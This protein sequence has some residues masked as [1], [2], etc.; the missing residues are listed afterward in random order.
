M[1]LDVSYAN[2]ATQASMMKVLV[3]RVPTVGGN[4]TLAPTGNAYR[5]LSLDGELLPGN[6]FVTI[7][8]GNGYV[9]YDTLTVNPVTNTPCC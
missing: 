3:N 7:S 6:N 5:T 2:K 9:Y 1:T 8:G 4:L